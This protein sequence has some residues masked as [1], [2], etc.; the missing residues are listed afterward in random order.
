MQKVPDMR[1][2]VVQAILN[3]IVQ[4]HADELVTGTVMNFAKIEEAYYAIMEKYEDFH[5]ARI[6]KFPRGTTT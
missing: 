2:E 5:K 6:P 3:V 1:P 4:K